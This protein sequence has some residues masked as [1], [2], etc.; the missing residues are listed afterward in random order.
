MNKISDLQIRIGADASGLKRELNET[1]VALKTALNT[2]P[3]DDASN[4][5]GEISK[6][7][8]SLIGNFQKL[9]IAAGGAF[10]LGDLI[11]SAVQAGDAVYTLSSR[12]GISAGEAGQLSRILKLTGGDVNSAATAIMRLD[13]S[14]TSAGTA[15]DRA[16]TTLANYGVSLTDASGKL[17]PL[18]QQLENLATGY[19]EAKQNGQEQAFL[20]DTLGVKGMA[21][22]QTLDQYTEAAKTAS[23]VQGIG[24]DPKEMHE[25]NQQ[26]KVMQMESSQVKL[27]FVAA[28]APVAQSVF[29][30]I[31]GGL[32]S[33]AKFLA[34]N[35]QEVR[36]I[37]KDVVTFLAIYKS[38]QLAQSAMNGDKSIF[39]TISTAMNAEKI[40]QEKAQAEIA[41][42]QEAMIAKQVAT[43]ERSYDAQRKAAIRAATRMN[44]SA[45]ET[46]NLIAEKLTAIE[47]KSTETAER[48]AARMREGFA[49][50]AQA[51]A[52]S[53]GE[54]D[55][56]LAG[57]GTAAEAAAARVA[58]AHATEAES[59]KVAITA[60]KE[61]AVASA[62]S[63]NAA[64]VAGEKSV[65]AKTEVAGATARETVAEEAL[66]TAEATSGTTASVA[67][68]KAVTAA[69]TA[70]AATERTTIATKSLTT[71]TVAQTGAAS[72]STATM[73]AGAVTATSKIRTLA[74]AVLSLA[75][76][77][78]V[79]AAAFA[80]YQGA[81]AAE[82]YAEKKGQETYEMN[83]V[84]YYHNSDDGRW[85][86]RE[87]NP[88][89]MT[90]EPTMAGGTENYAGS[91]LNT[92]L[93][94]TH[95]DGQNMSLVTDIDT[96]KQLNGM[97]S[98]RWHNSEVGRLSDEAEDAK[99]QALRAQSMV[100]SIS[101]SDP[102]MGIAPGG[103]ES[104]AGGGSTAEEKPATPMR[105]KYSFEDDPELAP[106][107]NEIEYASA[108]RGLDAA[109]LAAIIKTES[110]GQ[111]DIWSTDHAHWG[112]GQ[113]SQ[114]I[115][116]AYGGGRGYGEGSDPNDNI[117][118]A[119]G[120]LRDLLDQYGNDVELAISAYNLG[121]ANPS[122]NPDY[123]SKVEGYYNAITTSQV[124]MEGGSASQ[125]Q[126]TTVDVPIGVSMYDEASKNIGESLGENTC[127]HFVSY[128]AQGI[129]ANTG[130]I[131]DLVKD[132][133]DTAQANG[134]WVD[135]S[136][137]QTAPKGS[138]VVWSDGA[139]DNPW[140]HI[141]ISDGGGGWISSDTHGVK[142]STGLDSYY[143]GY[144]YAGYIDM[145]RLTGGQS[146]KMTVDASQKAAEE[147]AKRVK[148]A[149]DE[150]NK[151]LLELRT[152]NAKE[153][154]YAY[155]QESMKLMSDVAEKAAKIRKLQSEGAPTAS[156]QA[157][158]KELN[159]YT[160]ATT[161]KFRQKWADAYADLYD[162]SQ[163]ALAKVRHDYDK[164]ADLEYLTTVRKLNK[165]L[166]EKKKA[167]MHDENDV[168]TRKLLEDQYYAQLEEAE[169]K[170]RKARQEAH[171]QYV[172][173]LVEE[174]N[175]A[176][177][178]QYMGTSQR[179]ANGTLSK[180]EGEKRGESSLNLQGEKA[181]A[182]EYV[183][184]WQT[185]H[186]SMME[187]IADISDSLYSTMSESMTE[188]VKGT[189]SAKTVLQDFG[190]S[191]LN[192]MAKIAAQRFAATWVDN[193]LGAF[194][195]ARGG[196]SAWTWGGVTHDSSFGVKSAANQFI[197]SAPTAPSLFTVPKFAAGGIVTAPT[198]AMIGEGGDR[199]AVIPLNDHNL[200]AMSGAGKGG[201]VIVNITNN[202]DSKATVKSSR[203]DSGINK[204]ILDIVIDGAS[205]NVDGFGTNLKQALR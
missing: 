148:Q 166:E 110:H 124:P 168:E 137:G 197:S 1:Q 94:G 52:T 129:G 181:L 155:Q 55:A 145:D 178:V 149:T 177:L 47:L 198:L 17:L 66:T 33:T 88:D 176:M 72:R 108:Y 54:M 90:I 101:I 203:Y 201:G 60:E 79:A 182:K 15:G 97:Q 136:S 70:T 30:E 56:A 24:L 205:R 68:G 117:M 69:N 63:G 65:A 12:L 2:K 103:G 41:A 141:G 184:L 194:G 16:K 22:A 84:T 5:I 196:A 199:E 116:N 3:I 38:I 20:M 157:L 45:E 171:D 39:K 92:W 7:T 67:G 144:R 154:G 156:I 192:M 27:A 159:A 123:V 51:A 185:A 99:N 86:T 96:L 186:G 43:V 105:T 187:Y 83:G 9:A 160:A 114:D 179:N 82:A 163:T 202:S 113:I 147:A 91:F 115:A 77:W 62:E 126:M 167:L 158:K 173:Y 29:P 89:N 111:S 189:K 183:K 165:E 37:T 50:A 125:P 74:G 21:L 164:E 102:G 139:A 128:L 190:N 140:A 26:M 143:S 191:V 61:L 118:A 169:D 122:A 175:L 162:A 104:A 133:I 25:L 58:G 42:K 8:G 80:A 107:A 78:W 23:K 150:A 112:L 64:V 200:A 100:D 153:N 142:H 152:E 138:L 46:A 75:S 193:I 31:I 11:S 73:A 134:A 36:D 151:M 195:G 13:K 135:A 109:L 121:H 87:T 53:A 49:A 127:A 131:S 204:Q 106:W 172:N 35:K 130:V 119:A 146:T 180:S 188:F 59:A 85:Y 40:A 18:N 10:G 44:F 28:L 174:G 161:E 6:Q 81:K 4:K 76:S 48:V 14:F 71:A 57:T 170:R 93:M 34:Q 19:K 120:Y 95:S 132:W 32:T 98:N